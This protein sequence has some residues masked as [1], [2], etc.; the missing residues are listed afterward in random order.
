MEAVTIKTRNSR[1]DTAPVRDS[2][3]ASR[4]ACITERD[5]ERIF[6]PLTRYRYLPVTY[7]HALAG[8][9]LDYLVNR[10]NLLS[11]VPNLYVRRPRQQRATAEANHLP[12]VYELAPRGWSVMQER[13]F[14]RRDGRSSPNFAHELMVCQIMA[15]I[16]FGTRTHGV[17]L[18]GWA[19]ILRSKNLPE[20][21]RKS[22]KPWHIPVAGTSAAQHVIADG[23]PFGICREIDAKPVYFFC[24]GIEADCGTEPIEAS[25]FCRSSIQRKFAQYLAIEAAGTFRTHFGFPNLYTPFITTTT[26]RLESMIRLLLRKT[27]G[28]G[29]KTILFKTFPSARSSEMHKSSGDILGGDWRRA[30]HP[31]FNFLSS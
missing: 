22:T 7:L 18:I 27:N 26:A 25:D 12:L 8:G 16:E 29:S 23:S 1:W 13:G 4:V 15:S 20:G 31:N 9:S 21:T 24:P 30:G 11:R 6:E 19:D 2:A 17:Q 10:L 28:V 5:I 14:H 3:G